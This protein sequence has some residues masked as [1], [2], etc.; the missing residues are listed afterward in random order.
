MRDGGVTVAMALVSDW[1]PEK[2][3]AKTRWMMGATSDS[4]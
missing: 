4:R 3:L 2:G 1:H